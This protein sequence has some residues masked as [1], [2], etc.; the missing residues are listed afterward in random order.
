MY[1]LVVKSQVPGRALAL[2]IRAIVL[3]L[4]LLL[5][6]SSR[7]QVINELA[8]SNGSS[9]ENGGKFP[10]WIELY[11]QTA[12][13]VNLGSMS[14]FMTNPGSSVTFTF[15][16]VNILLNPG[17]FLVVWCDSDTNSPGFHTGF[18]LP[19]SSGGIL[20]LRTPGGGAN[21]DQVTF[22][23]QLTD[24]TVGRVP[25]GVGGFQL[26]VP[27]PALP[28]QTQPVGSQLGLRFNEWMATNSAG[29]NKDWLE[30]YNPDQL[31]VP[32]GGLIFAGSTN[33]LASKPA[34]PPLSFIDSNGFFRFWADGN[35][36]DGADH[37]DFKLS[38]TSGESNIWIY[39]PDRVTRF[40]HIEFPAGQVRD[41][42]Q[43]RLPDGSTNIVYFPVG[44]DTPGDSNFLPLT[45]A[46]INEILAHTDPPLEDAIE[47]Y[48]PTTD[49]LDISNW[50]LS[51]N[52]N[53]PFKFRIPAGTIMAPGGYKVF[54]EQVGSTGGFNTS[55]TG[56][57]P[58]FTLNAAHG[59][60]VYLF[61][62][63]ASGKLTGFRRG[64]NFEASGHG[65]SFGRY[66]NSVGD[67]D[68]TA[69]SA[70]SFG[71]DNPTSV[72]DFRQGTGL[73]NPYP[74]VGPVVIN[75]VMYK[76]PNI[77]VTNDNS[78]DEYIEL[79]NIAATNVPLYWV[80]ATNR[81]GTRIVFTN[82]WKIDDAV[83][84]Q[85]PGAITLPVDGYLLVVN[86]DPQTN[87]TQLA[88]FRTKY[89]VPPSFT[90]IYGPYKGKLK[91]SSA[92]VKL[93]RPDTVQEANRPD[94]GFVPFVL[95][96]KVNYGDSTPWPDLPDGNGAS[97][98]RRQGNLYGNDPANW[99]ALAPT[100]GRSNVFSGTI[101]V[102]GISHAG[103]RVDIVFTAQQGQTYT[104]EYKNDLAAPTW[105]LLTNIS[106]SASAPVHAGDLL[107]SPTDAR[108]YRVSTPKLP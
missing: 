12:G 97:L 39:L 99:G 91:N 49:A 62:G 79:H 37:L 17:Q 61:T 18:N 94:A 27:T 84:Y 106:S 77:N 48:N 56:N 11:N 100:P 3:C 107:F 96:D 82:G 68:I 42:S 38:S 108:F 83:T 45:N 8:A 20:Y 54:Y 104:V 66:V 60:E 5:A 101:T 15:P 14:L 57:D 73:P 44:R 78:N 30:L 40:E 33:S 41:Q 75:E 43:G 74:K 105:N 92:S 28:N 16:A 29:A 6:L 24:L 1:L 71:H 47:L 10:D 93:Y 7:A 35:A 63:D 72:Q 13:T 90:R 22:G 34:I 69:M 9:V 26:T 55:G 59:G 53:I 88:D 36:K 80:D 25:D 19:K 102:D 50:W 86:F 2:S 81:S 58:D 4:L 46:I 32:L 87:L 31:P 64:I 70:L 65:I 21:L 67:V 76:P 103:A 85:L 98:Q 95:M 51:N 23:L 52:R 89:G